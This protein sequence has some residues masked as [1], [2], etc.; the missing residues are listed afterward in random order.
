MSNI[1]VNRQGLILT[2]CPLDA[3]NHGIAVSITPK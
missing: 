1:R 2:F 3:G